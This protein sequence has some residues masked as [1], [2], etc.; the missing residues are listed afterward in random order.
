MMLYS[1]CVFLQL[2]AFNDSTLC[3]L[4]GIF[5]LKRLQAMQEFFQLT[6]Q[7]IT[8]LQGTPTQYNMLFR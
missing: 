2:S 4:N 7:S 6:S 1:V 3:L 8:S 5:F